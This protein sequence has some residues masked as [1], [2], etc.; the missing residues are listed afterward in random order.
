MNKLVLLSALMILIIGTIGTVLA[1][2]SDEQIF[3]LIAGGGGGKVFDIDND[4]VGNGGFDVG[5]VTVCNDEENIYVNFATTGDW[6]ITETHLHVATSVDGI[7]QTKNGNPKP[8]KFDY[9]TEHES[10]V[11]EYTYEIP[12]SCE[13]GTEVFIGAHAKVQV[14]VEEPGKMTTHKKTAWGEGEEFNDDRNWAMY[15]TY[16]IPSQ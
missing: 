6:C 15:I 11:N 3:D 10:C 12:F 1:G 5:N 8:G 2:V 7:P 13:P 16:T 4:T 9:S 14:E